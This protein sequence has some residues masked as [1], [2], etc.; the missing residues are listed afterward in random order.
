MVT[1]SPVTRMPLLGEMRWTY[2]DSSVFSHALMSLTV[3]HPRPHPH[4]LSYPPTPASTLVPTHTHVT[5]IPT[6]THVTLVVLP[7]DLPWFPCTLVSLHPA[8][9]TLHPKPSP[10]CTP[11]PGAPDPCGP[12]P[13]P[14]L[15]L[16]QVTLTPEEEPPKPA[17]GLGPEDKA[18]ADAQYN[19]AREAA[20]LRARRRLA[21]VI[22]LQ[23]R[24]PVVFK[25]RKDLL[26][27]RAKAKMCVCVGGGGEGGGEG[28]WEGL[29]LC[30]GT[31]PR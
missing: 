7:P 9:C 27:A 11:A 12:Y 4:P 25:R 8:P 23:Q 17:E 14:L 3:H 2:C 5:L 28:G 15:H 31:P 6:H 16:P 10:P 29:L 20:L 26:A 19:S 24:L 13:T 22:L 18:A 30:G 1:W 21:A